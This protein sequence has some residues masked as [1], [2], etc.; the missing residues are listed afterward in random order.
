[1]KKL[2]EYRR[3]RDFQKTAEPAGIPTDKP[4]KAR[5]K[6]LVF[7]IQKHAATRLHYDLR[8]QVGGVMKSW[9]V[10]KGPSLNPADKR[11]AVHVEDHPMEYNKFEGSIPKGQYGGGEVIIWDNGTYEVEGE[12]GADEQIARG[13]F[14]F[15]L[16]GKKVRG[17]FVLVKLKNS[18]KKNEW[19]LIK[20]KDE[21]VDAQWG[22]EQHDQS[23]VTGR[24][25]EDIKLGRPGHGPEHE[26]KIA[27]LPG[28]RKTTL[29]RAVPLTLASIRDKPFSNRDWLF[30]VKWDGIRGLIYLDDGD[31][32]VRSRA[33]RDITLE[34]P[35]VREIAT[36]LDAKQAII[37]GEIV[38]LDENG[39]SVFQKLQN[40]SG[41]RNPS[42][43]LLRQVPVTYYAFDLLYCDGYDLRKTPLERR[44]ELL[45]EILRPNETIRYSAHEVEKGVELYDAAREQGLEGILG[46]K[47]NSAYVGQRTDLWL[48]FKIVSE[49]D[50]V[51]AGWT[52][53]R[54][55]R[56]FFGALVL[57]LY[58]GHELKFIGSAGSGFTYE[59]QK[60]IFARLSNLRQAQSAFFKPPKLREV[61]EWVEPRLVVRIKYGNWTEEKRLRAPVFLGL[62]DDVD[63]QQ[64]TMQSV[65]PSEDGGVEESPYK[66]HDSTRRAKG[67]QAAERSNVR[68][69]RTS[70]RQLKTN[71][72]TPAEKSPAPTAIRMR[73]TESAMGN[74]RRPS[75]AKAT[76][77]GERVVSED[78]ERAIR[79]GTSESLS[80]EVNGHVVRLTHLNKMYFPESGIRKRDLIAY[81]FRI[82]PMMLPFLKDRPLVLRRYPNGISE[83]AFFQKEAPD[84]IPEWLERAIVYSEDRGRE[85]PYVMAN[86]LASLIYLTNLGCIDHNPWSSRAQSQRQPDYVFFD[87]DPTP[88]TPFTTVLQIAR[89]IYAIL[90]SIG[91]TCFMKT[92]GA[93]GFHIFVPLKPEYTYDQTRGFAE[94]VGRLAAE[95]LPGLITFERIVHKRPRGKVLM[96]ALQNARGKPLATV[97]S[98]RAYPGAPVST[99]VT[100]AELK[101][102]FAADQWTVKTLEKRLQKTGN[103]WEN[104]WEKRQS[105]SEALELLDT[106]LSSGKMK[107][108]LRR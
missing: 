67:K 105:F 74:V 42:Q 47:R 77:P 83:K 13:D 73:A 90:N 33:S 58:D 99:P 72:S 76:K 41:V 17:S 107:F 19:L 46:K 9:A 106:K 57:G 38:A 49:L 12:T 70:V 97:Y 59:S 71:A 91:L 52:A 60:M 10:P 50:A 94:L 28:A 61:I 2:A 56:E 27:A 20:H 36:R 85:M 11:L 30:E 34:F 48:K 6:K 37:D 31:V 8:L 3:K 1:M 18:Q 51:V 102:D 32:M 26:T 98:A 82:G 29:P 44:K 96:D 108:R 64:C 78:V 65:N 14:K 53:P 16:H 92:S 62:R 100:A 40:R 23:I 88:G 80:V 25:L 15:N 86:D 101:K 7:V 69:K 21:F 93:S 66:N 84:S 45:Q 4:L 79:T 63:P 5:Q 35:E 75:V 68:V 103:L 39:R 43:T 54:K 95:E 22:V 89:T 55:T 81:Y 24:T 104:F 87:L